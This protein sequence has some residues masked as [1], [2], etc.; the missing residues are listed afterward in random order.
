MLCLCLQVLLFYFCHTCHLFDACNDFGTGCNSFA[1]GLLIMQ[2]VRQIAVA[3]VEVVVVAVEA[4][5]VA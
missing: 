5:V 1:I 4:L 2:H 3:A